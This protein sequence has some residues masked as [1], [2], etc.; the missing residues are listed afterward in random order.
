[1]SCARTSTGNPRTPRQQHDARRHP[2][3]NCGR[4]LQR[5]DCLEHRVMA[6]GHLFS[7]AGSPGL[8]RQLPAG[9]N[10]D[11]ASAGLLFSPERRRC[12][13]GLTRNQTRRRI[14]P[15]ALA[16]FPP[17]SFETETAHRPGSSQRFAHRK[18]SPFKTLVQR[19]GAHEQGLRKD[20]SWV[21]RRLQ[22]GAR[23]L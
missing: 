17:G 19:L 2:H 22:R 4:V 3:W 1:M 14:C 9:A 11:P 5:S 18:S 12:G 10:S 21:T 15:P 16:A 23:C 13:D 7:Q 20:L 6:S 8:V